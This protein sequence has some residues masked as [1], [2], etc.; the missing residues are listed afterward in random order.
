MQALDEA[1]CLRKHLNVV[2][3]ALRAE[4]GA[5]SFGHAAQVRLEPLAELEHV[6]DDLVRHR[7]DRRLSGAVG[8]EKFDAVFAEP[9][10][11]DRLHQ[12][13]LGESRRRRH[14]HGQRFL[15]LNLRQH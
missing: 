15:G 9:D 10:G 13:I 3:T 5:A 7:R 11:A 2:L 12:W 1:H 14:D 8:N 6:I 4:L